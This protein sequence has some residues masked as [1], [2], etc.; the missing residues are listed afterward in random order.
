MQE[1]NGV[2]KFKEHVDSRLDKVDKELI[3]LKDDLASAIR[4]LAKSITGQSEATIALEKA[5]NTL[6]NQFCTFL[7]IASNAI[8]I[9]AVGWMF[10]II[11]VFIGGLKGFDHF[12]KI[13]S[14]LG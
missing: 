2:H 10:L 5:V 12:D 9:K 11:L 8:P 13:I 4:E 14:M 3:D 1:S 7:A 6:T